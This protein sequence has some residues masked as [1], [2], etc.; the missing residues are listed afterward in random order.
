MALNLHA[1]KDTSATTNIAIKSAYSLLD[2]KA[3]KLKPR[4]KRFLRWMIGIALE[5][6]NQENGTDYTQKDVYFK[7]QPEIPTNA[8]ENARIELTEAQKR[9]AEI[10]TVLSLRDFIDDE[11][12]LQLICEQLDIDYNEIKDKLPTEAPGTDPAAAQGIL[13]GLP[14]ETEEVITDA[15]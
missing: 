8:E 13:A 10:N 5:E 3:E 2:L 12:I 14:E 9:Q 15:E 4:L 11:T 1:L 6:I 7:F